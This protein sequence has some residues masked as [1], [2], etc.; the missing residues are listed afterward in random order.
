MKCFWIAVITHSKKPT[1]TMHMEREKQAQVAP[2]LLS[3]QLLPISYRRDTQ[4]NSSTVLKRH[5]LFPGVEERAGLEFPF[6]SISLQNVK[7]TDPPP[8]GLLRPAP[9][10]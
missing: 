6:P 3:D 10:P 1:S 8:K 4:H 9:T 2:H 7:N 5:I